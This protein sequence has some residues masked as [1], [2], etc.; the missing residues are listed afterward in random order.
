[1][2]DDGI[3]W[4][5]VKPKKSSNGYVVLKIT[6]KGIHYSKMYHVYIW[7]CL[8]GTK[9]DGYDIHH[10]NGNKTDNRTE[11][12]LC[13]D[14]VSHSRI[15]AGWEQRDGEMFKY[16][17][18]CA[19]LKIV[20]GSFYKHSSICKDCMREVFK[21]YRET[22]KV[23]IAEYREKNKEKLAEHG[24]KYREINKEKI[25]KY[26]E[27]TKDAMAEYQ[28]EYQKLNKEKIA[29]YQAT[30]QELNKDKIQEYHIEYRKLNKEKIAE[31]NAK[32]QGSHKEALAL[33]QLNWRKQ[34]KLKEQSDNEQNN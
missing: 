21:K 31:R 25:M 19:E 29:D 11:N 26:R 18:L 28:A 33:Y 8:Y 27:D 9:P 5:K 17:S 4:G 14:K 20:T 30:Y 3:D 12:L 1:M 16:C 7:E 23:Q 34:R 24:I 15:H 32:Y 2:V 10:I 13:V 22:H 6:I